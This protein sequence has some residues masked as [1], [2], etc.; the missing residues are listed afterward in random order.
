MARI[1]QITF[2]ACFKITVFFISLRILRTSTG[3]NL[4][5][6]ELRLRHDLTHSA[7]RLLSDYDFPFSKSYLRMTDKARGGKRWFLCVVTV[8][9]AVQSPCSCWQVNI[10]LQSNETW[11]VYWLKPPSL[12]TLYRQ[13]EGSIYTFPNFTVS[14]KNF[15][16]QLVQ[17]KELN[18]P[19]I[20]WKG[21]PF[22]AVW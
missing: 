18:A 2:I 11:C 9:R 13:E 21:M 10:Y 7:P 19:L 8:Q 22:T 16:R 12:W 4:Q 20:P 5:T 17:P 6:V 3:N 14:R 1:I 15:V